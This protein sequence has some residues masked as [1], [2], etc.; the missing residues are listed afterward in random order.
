MNAT[1][2]LWKDALAAGRLPMRQG[3][4]ALAWLDRAGYKDGIQA[5]NAGFWNVM[6]MIGSEWLPT[7]RNWQ[8]R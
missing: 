2:R 7:W 8:T 4:S 3:F 5:E 6:Q 1:G